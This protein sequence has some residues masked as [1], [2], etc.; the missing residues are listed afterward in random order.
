MV[1][2]EVP[3]VRI[4][5]FVLIA[6]ACGIDATGLM[7]PPDA[8]QPDRG[9]GAPATNDEATADAQ[10]DGQGRD[11]ARSEGDAP[12]ADTDADSA[13]DT[14]ADAGFMYE[15][16]GFGDVSSCASCSGRPT[17]C[18]FCSDANA[19][20]LRG[21]CLQATQACYYNA[22]SGYDV[23]RCTND[24]SQCPTIGMQVCNSFDNG[25][26][27]PCGDQYSDGVACRAGGT[28]DRAL[29]TCQ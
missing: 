3:S 17:A 4:G 2:R 20:Q 5:F 23:C 18:V 6:A 21:Q 26:C 19:T 7:A 22:P 15:C 1:S 12:A 10:G 28:C 11:D 24:V 16:P 29:R 8:A 14:G 25:Y 27:Q 9:V 13:F